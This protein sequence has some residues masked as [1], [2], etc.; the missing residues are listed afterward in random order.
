MGKLNAWLMAG[1]VAMVLT[2]CG[3]SPAAAPVG[4]YKA[5]TAKTIAKAAPAAATVAKQPTV[6]SK[7]VSSTQKPSAPAPAASQAPSAPAAGLETGSLKLS[8]KVTGNAPVSA[9]KVKVFEQADASQAMDVPLTLTAG[10]AS[11]SQD[12]VPPGRYTFQVQA[13]GADQSVIG[14]GSTEAI[15][16]A[17]KLA[18]VSLEL[19]V[20]TP[21]A[22]SGVASEPTPSTQPTQ[23]G[24]TIGL[25]IEIQ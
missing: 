14:S 22:T 20:N 6:S 8:L 21:D 18:D 1:L 17:G 25:N 4:T 15:V 10:A 13:I 7:P 11:W 2:G 12:E 9:V 5:A 3:K 23:I 19:R 16:T 24:G